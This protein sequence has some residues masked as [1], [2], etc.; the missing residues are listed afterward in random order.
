MIQLPYLENYCTKDFDALKLS[1]KHF[2]YCVQWLKLFCSLFVTMSIS[3]ASTTSSQALQIMNFSIKLNQCSPIV[4]LMV[5][6]VVP[7][8]IAILFGDYTEPNGQ[9]SHNFLYKILRM[10][11][12]KDHIIS[13]FLN[14]DEFYS[15]LFSLTK[16]TLRR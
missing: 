14:I 6:L 3:L 4:L 1:I 16:H 5:C 2:Y 11:P 12:Y 10:Q 9:Y 13:K 15:N 8:N 7:C